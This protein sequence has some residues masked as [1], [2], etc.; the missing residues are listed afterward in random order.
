MLVIGD[1]NATIKETCYKHKI[2]SVVGWYLSHHTPTQ[3]VYCYMLAIKYSYHRVDC[4]IK[5]HCGLI[6][7]LEYI[8]F[9]MI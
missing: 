6:A 1:Q 3:F 8:D 4:L 5:L 7:L 2:F 9:S